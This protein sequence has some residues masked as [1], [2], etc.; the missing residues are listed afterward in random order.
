MFGIGM[1]ELMV[2][3]IL[4]LVV[5]GAGRLPE[6]GRS[7]GKAI[8]GFKETMEEP[9]KEPPPAAPPALVSYP[10]PVCVACGKPRA[11]RRG[12]LLPLLRPAGAA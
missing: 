9:K 4:A 12:R 8:R 11:P 2:I 10:A 7:L 5:F 3:L 1:P 6:V